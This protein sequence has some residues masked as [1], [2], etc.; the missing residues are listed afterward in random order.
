MCVVGLEVR[1]WPVWRGL[2][3]LLIGQAEEEVTIGPNE[4]ER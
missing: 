4:G 2:A 1:G 3:D